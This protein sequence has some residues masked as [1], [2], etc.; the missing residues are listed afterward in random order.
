MLLSRLFRRSGVNVSNGGSLLTMYC[1]KYLC[2]GKPTGIPACRPV[3][4]VSS[5]KTF[6]LRSFKK[7]KAVCVAN[8]KKKKRKVKGKKNKAG[9]TV[10]PVVCGWA[11][12]IFEVTRPFG[13]EQ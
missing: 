1:S 10:I 8:G 5:V 7:A 6:F 9:Y 4:L 2:E 11:G 13:Q 3:G 12:A